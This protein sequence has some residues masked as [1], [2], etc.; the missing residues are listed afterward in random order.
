M[1]E[2][3][4]P[5]ALLL[6]ALAGGLGCAWGQK[7]QSQQPQCLPGPLAVTLEA[8]EQ[9]N[10]DPQGRS[11]TASVQILELQDA[12]A[13]QQL[14][15]NFVNLWEKPDAVLKE[16]LLSAV[17][18]TVVPGKTV[19]RRLERNPRARFI[20]ALVNFRQPL[21]TAWLSIYELKPAA[22]LQCAAPPL[23]LEPQPT[24]EQVR[25]HLHGYQI[26]QANQRKTSWDI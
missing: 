18:L 13:L 3:R 19:S 15:A 2:V 8:A 6:L 7:P 11:L 25:F 21:G 5:S 17:K 16:N 23:G 9:L 26:D 20:A 10:P 22:E 24:D 4:Y 14:D 1:R 12:A